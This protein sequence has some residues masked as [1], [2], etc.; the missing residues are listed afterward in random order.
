MNWI[1]FCAFNQFYQSNAQ[2]LEYLHIMI[3]GFVV[4][5]INENKKSVSVSLFKSDG[6]PA[7]VTIHTKGTDYDYNAMHLLSI[8]KGFKGSGLSVDD[9]RISGVTIYKESNPKS[10]PFHKIMDNH[11]IMIDGVSNYLS[12]LIPASS[13]ILFQLLPTF[14]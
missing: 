6:I 4:E 7:G 10:Y 8:N 5:I 9:E 12:I 1:R 2:E 13:H 3:N 11:E 14:K